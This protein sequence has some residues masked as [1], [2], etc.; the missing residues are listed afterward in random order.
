M[1]DKLLEINNLTVTYGAFKIITEV[2]I[3]LKPGEIVCIAGESGCGKSTLIKAILG[4]KQLGAQ[5]TEGKV[6]LDGRDITRIG[7]EERRQI[8]GTQIS[9]VPQN[10]RGSFN[11]IRSYDAQYRESMVSH[12][13]TFDREAAKKMFKRLN[14]PDTDRLLQYQPWEMSGGMNQRMA[15]GLAVLQKPKLMLCDEATSVLDVTSQK[16]V[17][18]ELSLL[19]N[20]LGWSI[21]FITH[22]LGVASHIADKLGV[23]YAGRMVEYG[24]IRKVLDDPIHP[25]TRNLLA[26]IPGKDRKL[27]TGLEGRPPLDGAEWTGCNFVPRCKYACEACKTKKYSLD[28][29]EPGHWVSCAEGRGQK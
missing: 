21:L 8:L 12:G 3:S 20:E 10:T 4:I 9:Y 16:E 18:D 24:D 2:S 15:V 28:E 26:A 25:Y 29:I 14:F 19:R 17:I 1:A 13:I 5:I 6:I 22:N 23:M 11:N 7:V 27:P